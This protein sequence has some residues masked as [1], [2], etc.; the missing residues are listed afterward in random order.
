[1]KTITVRFDRPLGTMMPQHGICNVDDKIIAAPDLYGY[2]ECVRSQALMDDIRFP[3]TCTKHYCGDGIGKNFDVP[4]VFRDF[5][6]DADDPQ[7]YFFYVTD[8]NLRRMFTCEERFF[9]YRLGAPRELFTPPLYGKVPSDFEKFAKV[10]VHIVMHF[11]DGWAGG[12]HAGIKYWSVWERPD[13]KYHWHGTAEEY[14]KLYEAT[15]KAIKQYDPSLK[16]G[17]PSVADM[18]DPSFLKNFL[19]YVKQHDVPCDFVSWNYAGEDISEAARQART[20]KE[21]VAACG[22]SEG[23]EII[24]DL[25]NYMTID[26]KGYFKVP[27]VR[28]AYGGAFDAAFMIEMQKA[29]MNFCTYYDGCSASPCGGLMVRILNKALKPMYSFSAFARLYRK[30][31]SCLVETE[32]EGISAL[33]AGT[34]SDGCALIA[35]CEPGARQ[36]KLNLGKGS[37]TVYL[38][39]EKNDMSVLYAGEDEAVTAELNGPSV[40][41]VNYSGKENCGKAYI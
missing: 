27:H 7:S 26:D 41:F 29:G 3:V 9:V 11:N 24:N 15:V 37:K 36:M 35:A 21:L 39:D 23:T 10:C 16:V 30:Q 17:G 18:S 34:A 14:F 13:D 40:L 5:S 6:K 32:G 12:M 4:Y 25:W 19:T 8:N 28:D 38:L 20:V 33:A 1:M 2:E 31:N 22:L